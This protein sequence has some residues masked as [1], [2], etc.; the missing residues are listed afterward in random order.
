MSDSH[1]SQ[2]AVRQA[3]L[4]QVLADYL[5]SVE[6][7]QPLDRSALVEAHPNLADDL[8]SF[9]R[10]HD[11]IGRLAEP[12]K[13]AAD[14]PTILGMSELIPSQSG[15]T[16]RYFG[17]YELLDEI[18]RGG[19]GVVFKARQVNLNRVVALKMIL[20]GQLA[21]DSDVKRF[22][23]EAEAAARLD[24]PGI[25][26]IFEIGQH[27]G[28]NYFS[29]AFVEGESLAKKVAKGPLPPREAAE[30]VKRVAEAVEYAHQKG[31]IH[32]DLKPANVLL[33]GQGQPKVT[34]F[35]LAKQIQGDSG[36]T[37]TGQILGT[38][39]YMPPEQASGK[40]D[41]VGVQ[42][43]V[44]AL[45]AL[46]YCLLT[47]RPPFQ[48][49]S[50]TDTL[51][52][53]LQQ[54]PVAPRQLNPQVPLDL[55]TIALKCLEK[56]PARRYAK[57][58]DLADEIGRFLRGEPILARP[59]GPL[60]RTWRWCK[61][62]RAVAGLTAAVALVLLAGTI[63]STSLGL[64]AN[65]NAHVASQNARE[66]AA[67]RDRAS[68]MSQVAL[69]EK[70]I[71]EQQRQVA[72]EQ[73]QLAEQ[74]QKEAQLQ[75]KVALQARDEMQVAQKAAEESRVAADGA[76]KRAET[77][78]YFNRVSLAYQYWLA[79]NLGGSRR[80]LDECPLD[81]RGWEWR[82]LDRIH[83]ADLLTLPGNGQ[84]TS[85]LKFSSDGKR[86]AAYAYSG[87]RGV[88]IWDL[89]ANKPLTE[90]TLVR[91]QR[92]FHC[93]DLSP[94][95]KTVALGDEAGAINIWNAETGQLIREF[96]R[97]PKS[98]SSLSFSPDGKWLAAARAEGRNGEQL[99]PL[100]EAARNE[101]LVV[102]DVATGEEVFHPKGHGFAALFSPDSSRLLSFKINTALRLHPSVPET[103]LAL[104]DTAGWTEVASEKTGHVRSFSFSG[105]GKRLAIGGQDRQRDVHF[106]RV[107]DPATGNEL[108]NLTPRQLVGD[109]ALNHD[110]AILAV[111][112][113]M[114]PSQIDVWDVK[115][116]RLV[117][118]LRGHTSFVNGISFS[119]DGRLASCS[120]DNTI[121]FWNTT[122]GQQVSR[123]PGH[124]MLA[125]PVE[126]A[127]GGDLLAY[128]QRNSVNLLTGPVRTITLVDAAT[129]KTRHTLAGH[130]RSAN[131]LAF[132]ADGARLVS[133]GR[134]GEVKVW[135]TKSGKAICSVRGADGEICA[136]ALS[137]DGHTFVS[138]HEPP[139][140]TRARFGQ[141]QFRQI[142]VAIKVWEADTGSERASL[143]GHP[144]GV[145]RLAFSPDGKVLASAGSG[146]IKFWDL[147]TGTERRGL[148]PEI[149]QSATSDLLLFSPTGN[150]LLTSG[151]NTLQLC[152]VATGRAITTIRSSVIANG[153]VISPDQS[154]MATASFDQV[155]LWDLK[156]GQEILT[157]PL[158]DVASA[159]K[160][161]V[162]ALQWT[163]DGQQLRAVSP[164]GAVLTWD[165]SPRP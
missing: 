98:V 52:Q 129:G 6:N 154:R 103:F 5:H 2:S 34:D 16:V 74:Q 122:G 33:D 28:Q 144:G 66:A 54:E 111:A 141:G 86:M 109:I 151:F 41:Q 58:I 81:R 102:W 23:A 121:K 161:R 88:R 19:M 73:R 163:A 150:H 40:L 105:D 37:G 115:Q 143:G 35:G 96:A 87:D 1:A 17:D 95:G 82:Y 60:E 55:E 126:F 80:I 10:N 36:L 22:Y 67:E 7:G 51:M 99:L 45:G 108:A 70:E 125:V 116:Q 110:G 135:D 137:P 92:S 18:A 25:V 9:F 24:H 165:G 120:W 53:V 101:D 11:S 15:M 21:N 85:N 113:S 56:E 4:E 49:A 157:L 149:Q 30:L 106:V 136:A 69:R 63:I 76:R 14:A 27:D 91:N 147:A 39:S 38:P 78:L 57:A 68:D 84:F 118:V 90:I 145:Y 130:A 159:E 20:A 12:L 119:P 65:H 139:E 77:A 131:C 75:S 114:G 128:G 100:A 32:R 97:L 146:G 50:P 133:G 156:T 46:L 158:S 123:T 64:M 132:S 62:N 94:D 134:N 43:D 138:V 83:H 3:K 160:P 142:P 155:K 13:A 59:V 164:D 112:S 44:Y 124:A 47:G 89:T 107:I 104:F 162:A 117:R 152:D 61:R 140:I 153:A 93:A 29:M 48:A 26:P 8:Q 31:I 71:A 72:D 148:E 79:D 127:P 42:S